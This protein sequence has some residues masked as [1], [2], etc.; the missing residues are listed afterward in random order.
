MRTISI[1]LLFVAIVVAAA[2]AARAGEFTDVIDAFD[3]SYNG[4]PF[5]LNLSVGYERLYKQGDI[6]RES[7]DL[8][9]AHKWDYYGY[10]DVA[11]YKQ[12]THIL[13]LA[14]DIGLFHDISLRTELPLVLSD[15]RSLSS[16]SGFDW[17]NTG[18]GQN[19]FSTNFKSPERSGLD[20]I[21]VG[22]WWGI[23]D[24]GRDDTKP[25]WTFFV[26]GRFSVG[27]LMR[28]A[29]KPTADDD[30]KY[31]DPDG[32]EQ[33]APSSSGVGRG[34]HEVAGGFRLSRRYHIVEPYFG[35]EALL[36]F[37][38]G[39]ND[40]F[41]EGDS[42]GM[43]NTRPPAVG[44]IDIGMEFIPWE[45]PEKE[46][47]LVIGVGTGGKYHSEGRER[48]PLY[49][50]LGTSE[51]FLGQS[52]VDMN[53]NGQNDGDDEEWAVGDGVWT[54]ATDIENFA[55]IFGKVFISIQPAKY[56]KF[57][58]GSNFAHETEHFITKTDQCPSD[59]VLNTAD[60]SGCAIYNW[61]YRPEL[62]TPGYR[63]RA[64]KT[65]VWDF[66]LDAAAQF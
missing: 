7:L 20:T 11:Q 34:I 58:I 45:V 13:N 51:H 64:E 46:R 15:S 42:M 37:S 44:T 17:A 62:D 28:A 12:T 19:L 29:C 52:Y 57:T 21:N 36:G 24:Q 59:Q 22:L 18:D 32:A 66:Y 54:G 26:E 48:T 1:G 55:T 5:D 33:N 38:A 41:I 8:A 2:P 61:G 43:L 65:F 10:V 40:Y 63:F 49:D 35:L 23:L 39:G 47:K 27:K 14:L 50:A 3:Q 53:A 56:V 16:K 60:G 9:N 6:R 25:N 30:C 4:D 31:V